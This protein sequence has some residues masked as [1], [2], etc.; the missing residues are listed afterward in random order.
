M[1]KKYYEIQYNE[2]APFEEGIDI[3]GDVGH[4]GLDQIMRKDF[5]SFKEF[6]AD[7]EADTKWW[8]MM[9]ISVWEEIFP[10]EWDREYLGCFYIDKRFKENGFVSNDYDNEYIPKVPKYVA[11][12]LQKWMS[13]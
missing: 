10:D 13:T 11:K 3:R 5:W 4:I 12:A 1:N 9:E 8:L 7:L 2:C 6:V